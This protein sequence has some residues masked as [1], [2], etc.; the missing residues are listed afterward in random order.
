MATIRIG[1]SGWVYPDWHG[2]FYPP[3][4]VQKR[5]L[6][7][8]SRKLNSIEINGT[9]YSLQTPTSFGKWAEATPDDF[10]F[11]MKGGKFITHI[12]RLREIDE[13]LRNYFASGMLRL[14]PKLGPILWQFPETFKFE[15]DRMRAFLGKLPR[16]TVEAAALAVEHT[17]FIKG[18]AWTETDKKRPVRHA[19]EMRHASW[20]CTEF[21]DMLR[22]HNA[23]WV[24]ADT[25]GKWPYFEEVTAD[26]V[27][28]RLHG[29]SELYTS[30]YDEA[31]LQR[32][33]KRIRAWH[34]GGEPA[35]AK[36]ITQTKAKPRPG[37]GRDVFVYFDNSVKTTAPGNAIRLGE[38]LNEK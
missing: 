14:G 9:F 19:F 12:K 4:L 18:R 38:I 5:E 24:V 34:G 22:D 37:R 32:W 13:P 10:V 20:A 3:D 36:R 28:V 6:E 26:F 11:T 33:A 25:A 1:I 17:D 15:P 16:D 29:E 21:A 7:Y 30:G 31:S 35:D 27:Y 8:A 23:A 2:V